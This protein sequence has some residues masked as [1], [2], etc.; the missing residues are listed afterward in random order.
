MIFQPSRAIASSDRTERDPQHA[1]PKADAGHAVEGIQEARGK[2]RMDLTQNDDLP[3]LPRDRLVRSD[4]ARP[5]ACTA[6]SG[7][8]SR[9]RGNSG[10]SWER[11][12]GPDSER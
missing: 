3:A 5:T 6:K 11:A 12:D 2:E 10:G 1:R 9:R 8:G 7:C 4:R